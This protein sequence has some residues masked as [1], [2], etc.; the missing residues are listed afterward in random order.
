MCHD[1]VSTLAFWIRMRKETFKMPGS[2]QEMKVV[3]Y[4][5]RDDHVLRNAALR[6]AAQ[7]CRTAICRRLVGHCN[8]AV[9]FATKHLLWRIAARRAP[10]AIS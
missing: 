2:S 10:A 4:M 3:N 6:Q 8:A 9:L 7:A 5:T 1:C